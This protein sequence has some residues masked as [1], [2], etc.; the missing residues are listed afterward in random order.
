MTGEMTIRAARPDER[1]A[2]EQLQWRASLVAEEYREQLLANPDAIDLPAEQ[3]AQGAVL[4]ADLE[5]QTAGFAVVLPRQDGDAELD[6]MFVKPALWRAGVGRRLLDAAAAL[7]RSRGA[8]V[9]HV[10]A[11]PA[12]VGFYEACGFAESG[13][14]QTRFG[15][16]TTMRREISAND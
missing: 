7:A 12:A 5:A 14:E 3:L 1:E 15:P 16:A 6:G 2:L 10:I 9:L 4:V 8:A 13:V 11:N